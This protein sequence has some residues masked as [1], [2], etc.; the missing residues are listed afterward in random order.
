MADGAGVWLSSR[1]PLAWG[2]P[3]APAPAPHKDR[4][5]EKMLEVHSSLQFEAVK[6]H[7]LLNKTTF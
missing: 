2:E 3:W 6:L 5:K 1:V 4:E 7:I